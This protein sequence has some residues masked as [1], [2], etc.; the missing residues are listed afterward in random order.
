MAAS[1][2]ASSFVFLVANS[3]ASFRTPG[4]ASLTNSYSSGVAHASPICACTSVSASR[5]M[6]A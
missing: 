2:G 6:S 1:S 3:N 4:S 5:R